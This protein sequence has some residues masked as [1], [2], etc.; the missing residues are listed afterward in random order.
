VYGLIR[1]VAEVERLFCPAG[2]EGNTG[3]VKKVDNF[4]AGR[5]KNVFGYNRYR[6][7]SG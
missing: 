6:E 1:P 2:P 3:G 7:T 4:D 5:S